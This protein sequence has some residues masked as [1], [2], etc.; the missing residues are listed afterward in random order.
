MKYILSTGKSSG[1]SVPNLSFVSHAYST[2]MVLLPR[3][4]PWSIATASRHSSRVQNLTKLS[5]KVFKVTFQ[6]KS[7]ILG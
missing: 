7:T 6:Y 5:K 1:L 4:Q 3:R 2:V